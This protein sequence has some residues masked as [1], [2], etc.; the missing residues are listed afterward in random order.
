MMGDPEY[1]DYAIKRV[2]AYIMS[3]IYPGE[4]LILTSETSGAPINIREI[5]C[6]IEH[7]LR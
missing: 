2:S 1:A 5:K 6:L 7:F 3:G 4:Q